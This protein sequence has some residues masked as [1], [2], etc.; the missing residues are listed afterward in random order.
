MR[1][2]GAGASTI[3][4]GTF[5]SLCSPLI[6]HDAFASTKAH[7]SGLHHYAVGD[8]HVAGHY[9]R[10]AGHHFYRVA[11]R[12]K[13]G[14]RWRVAVR[15]G[16]ISCVPFAR[17]DSG[18][19]LAGNAWQWWDHAAG[20]YARGMVPEEGSVLAFRSNPRMRLGHVAVV[21][22][23]VNDRE[24]EID[25][26]NW[27]GAGMRGGV[28]HNV[29]VVDVSEAND[30]SAVRV[31]LGRSGEFGSVYPTYG[32]IYD[33]PDTGTAMAAVATPAPQPALNPA[34]RDLRPVAERP[35]ST[36]EEVAQAPAPAAGN[37]A[38]RPIS[39]AQELSAIYRK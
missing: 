25:Q 6:A 34:P 10:V 27:W 4:L 32:F 30:W 1:A 19:E 9:A 13:H 17:S 2:R 22:R 3:V 33:R 11:L 20:V 15:G 14:H 26:A 24:V 31:G 29:P 8:H 16:G 38:V 36:F 5:L 28:S 21:S 7:R 39:S 35:W 18:I 12:G 23:I 37:G